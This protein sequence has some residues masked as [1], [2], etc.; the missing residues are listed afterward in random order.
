M[1]PSSGGGYNKEKRKNVTGKQKS[2]WIRQVEAGPIGKKE[3][4]TGKQNSLLINLSLDSI[5]FVNCSSPIQLCVTC[6][7]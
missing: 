3:N 4:V 5:N 6:D 2:Q 1:D 7:S